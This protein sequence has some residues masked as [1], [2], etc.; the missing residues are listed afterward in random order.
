ME[1][2]RYSN[3][4]ATFLQVTNGQIY[5]ILFKTK[6]CRYGPY[7]SREIVLR[8]VGINAWP[9][10]PTISARIRHVRQVYGSRRN[11]SS[12]YG[13]VYVSLFW[14]STFMS[15]LCY[16]ICC[17]LKFFAGAML[18]MLDKN[19]MQIF[20]GMFVI[21]VYLLLLPQHF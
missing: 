4:P 7:K 2:T 19:R 12:E 5:A 20:P 17:L 15:W 16:R 6:P 10:P 21:Q 8:S 14:N 9:W 13:R 3:F 1:I 11:A 18:L